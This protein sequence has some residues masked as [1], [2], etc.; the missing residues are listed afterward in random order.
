VPVYICFEMAKQSSLALQTDDPRISI[1]IQKIP[2][3][4]ILRLYEKARIAEPQLSLFEYCARDIAQAIT[5]P[6]EICRELLGYLLTF[7]RAMLAFDGLDEILNTAQRREFVDLVVGFVDQFPLC[8]VLVTS[9]VIGYK[10]A[11]M[12]P[13]YDEFTLSPFNKKEVEHY[14]DRFFAKVFG[15]RKEDRPSQISRFMLQTET[16]AGDLRTNPLMLG[17]LMEIFQA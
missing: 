11:P 9:R 14:L 6:L 15:L 5:A 3:R 7:G 16:N 17:R 1:A 4:V 10:N 13:D 2:L 12:P 8:P